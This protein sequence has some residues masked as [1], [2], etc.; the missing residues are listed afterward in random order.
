MDEVGV[1]RALAIGIPG[2]G[3]YDEQAYVK[4]ISLWGDRLLPVACVDPEKM[5]VAGSALKYL[6][7]LKSLG[8]I[9]VKIHPRLH[10][11]PR[12]TEV[13]VAVVRGAAD[14][15]LLPLVCTYS[16]GGVSADR[17]WRVEEIAELLEKT[18]ACPVVLLHGGGV[19][20]ME[21]SEVVRAY[22]NTL[23][24][25]SFT[26]LKYEG[27][28]L[29]ADLRFLCAR[30]DRRICVGSDSPDFSMKDLRR[31]IA[32]LCAGLPLEKVA[33]IAHGNLDRQLEA[34]A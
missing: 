2:I 30:F 25:L 16:Y 15:G 10:R 27:S 9:G 32:G 24:D 23:L 6:R 5:Q 17:G 20:L 1:R 14:S 18:D 8:Y 29:D 7:K 22:L 12:P 3:A 34:V 4:A 31:R 26:M 28:S 11:L 13:M 19:R 21:M 33:A